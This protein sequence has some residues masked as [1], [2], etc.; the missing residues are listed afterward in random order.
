MDKYEFGRLGEEA[1][2]A[3]MENLGYT[4]VGRNVRVG[5]SEIDIICRNEKYLLFV[6]VKTRN[7]FPGQKSRYGPPR[8]AVNREKQDFLIR[9][10]L[11]YIRENGLK[12]KFNSRIDVIEVFA[13]A[14]PMFV[15]REIKYHKNAV[16][17]R[18]PT[19]GPSY[20]RY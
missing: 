16:R 2:A 19:D 4:I 13:S 5:H 20:G 9:G 3:Y 8:L 10:V 12:H 18:S 7:M 17:R 1:A 6:E 11:Q 15:V 14:S